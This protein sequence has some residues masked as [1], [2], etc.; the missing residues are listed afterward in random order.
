M[1]QGSQC[2]KKRNLQKK[3]KER[4]KNIRRFTI[5]YINNAKH[6]TLPPMLATKQGHTQNRGGLDYGKRSPWQPSC[7]CFSPYIE[8]FSWE[9]T[10]HRT[11]FNREKGCT[12]CESSHTRWGLGKGIPRQPYSCKKF[13]QN[14]AKRQFEPRTSRTQVESLYYCTRPV[15][16]NNF[17]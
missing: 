3:K 4:K 13:L 5:N 12:Q 11:I 15:L 8:P 10:Q 7:C 1:L 6:T 14:S 17:N 16:E 2:C 9:E